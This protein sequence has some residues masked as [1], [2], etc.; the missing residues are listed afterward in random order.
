MSQNESLNEILFAIALR[1]LQGL[2]LFGLS[3]SN[4]TG[5]G[6]FLARLHLA[7]S[8]WSNFTRDN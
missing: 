8:V 7:R 2:A 1:D 3:V 6:L 5:D 4:R